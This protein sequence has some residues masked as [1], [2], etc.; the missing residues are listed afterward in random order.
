[1]FTN[2]IA[3]KVFFNF[4]DPKKRNFSATESEK[5]FKEKQNKLHTCAAAVGVLH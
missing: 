4:S 1:M 2:K 5:I 3:R